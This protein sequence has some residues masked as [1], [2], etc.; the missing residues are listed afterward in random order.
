MKCCSNFESVPE[1]QGAVGRAGW[2]ASFLDLPGA[3]FFWEK[4]GMGTKTKKE[5]KE[6]LHLDSCFNPSEGRGAAPR[7]HKKVTKFREHLS[8]KR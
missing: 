4:P 8:K 7:S 5:D 2:L 3:K 1:N 6:S